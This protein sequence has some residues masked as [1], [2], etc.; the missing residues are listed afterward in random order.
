MGFFNAC[1]IGK[2]Q[3]V[4]LVSEDRQALPAF[5]AGET[6]CLA[7]PISSGRVRA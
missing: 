3:V 7:N 1:V 4:E 2:M 6:A 5:F